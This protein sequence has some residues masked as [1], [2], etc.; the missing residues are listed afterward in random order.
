[1]N[2]NLVKELKKLIEENL[3]PSMFPY[4]KG[5]SIRIG[6]LVIRENKK[7]FHIHN[8]KT[9][10]HVATTFSKTA[11]VAIAKNLAKGHNVTANA[12]DLDKVIE[13]NFS[14]ALFY[15][16]TLRTTKDEMKKEVTETRLDIAKIRTEDAKRHLDCMIFN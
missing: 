4:A 8:L 5:N 14:D 9:K 6:S 2:S 13:K 16:H 12:I 3:D 1:M 15:S 10:D 11:A 7:G